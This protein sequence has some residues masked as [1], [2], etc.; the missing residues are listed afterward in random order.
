MLQKQSLFQVAKHYV[1]LKDDT[2]PI[3]ID[4]YNAEI[5][6]AMSRRSQIDNPG[7]S[8]GLEKIKQQ[9]CEQEIGQ[10]VNGKRFFDAIY[11]QGTFCGRD[12]GIIHQHI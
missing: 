12:S 10:D 2:A 8:A 3:T 6:E 11:G 7:G 4:Q 1:E 9:I 5:D